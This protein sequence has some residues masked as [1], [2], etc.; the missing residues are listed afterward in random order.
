MSKT[1]NPLIA[2]VLS[3]GLLLSLMSSTQ[4][5]LVS[6]GSAKAGRVVALTFDD[7]P[8]RQATQDILDIL[9]QR[10]QPA[11]FFVLGRSIRGQERLVQQMACD[12]H[13]VANH[14]WAHRA[15]TSESPQQTDTSIR[16]TDAEIIRV[17]GSSPGW[18]R[19]PY[20]ALPHRA[21]ARLQQQHGWRTVLW[22]VDTLD[23]Q[24]GAW[25]ARASAVHPGAII[26]MHDT[27]RTTARHL[28]AFLD[29]LERRGYTV[30]PLSDLTDLPAVDQKGNCP[31]AVSEHVS[32]VVSDVHFPKK[33]EKTPHRALLG[34]YR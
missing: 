25:P 23:W 2:S 3:L 19:P 5:Q 12:G 21:A 1:L 31:S 24:G 17:L 11:T 26:L 6:R 27:H 29:D 10:G 20:G 7:G 13:V 28:N 30:V 8:S 34:F 9:R 15:M 16:K 14:S 32:L 18:F 4:N 33:Q 22:S